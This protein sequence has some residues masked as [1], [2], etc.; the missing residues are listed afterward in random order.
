MD[1]TLFITSCGRPHLLKPT[2][3]SFMKFNTYPIKEAIICEDSGN[4]N[5]IDFVKD[6]LN[7]PCRIIYNEK[8]IGQMRSIENGVKYITTPYVFHCEDDWEFY[9]PGFIEISMRI[10][11][12]N[13]KISQV[14]LRSYNEYINRYHFKI[15]P[16]DNLCSKIVLND[17]KN[18][19]SFN[20]S[21]KKTNIQLL[22]IP[23]QDWDD[24]YTIQSKIN[25]LGLFAVVTKNITGY[26]R[27]IGWNDHINESPDI[28]YR[29]QFLGK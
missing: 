22:N 16:L 11:Q 21:L 6:I 17:F 4:K 12:E 20:P 13:D 24:E 1:V 26:V 5:S 9:A 25:D 18:I 23:Y 19:Y 2:L 14:L 7:F 15:L 8:R 28:K 27:H 10:L 29:Y 3:E